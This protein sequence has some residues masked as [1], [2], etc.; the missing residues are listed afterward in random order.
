MPVDK[1]LIKKRKAA[2][3]D[4]FGEI[5]TLWSLVLGSPITEREVALMMADLKRA[6]IKFIDNELSKFP[7][8]DVAI[9]L[10]KSRDDNITDRD[11]YMW[12]AEN[13]DAYKEL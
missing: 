6:R 11:N 3:G 13:F 8:P 4:N 9:S 1:N 12:I 10:Y 7:N 2:Y 5:S